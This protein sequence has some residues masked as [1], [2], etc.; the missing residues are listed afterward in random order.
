MCIV[1]FPA[2]RRADNMYSIP[3]ILTLLRVAAVPLLMILLAMPGPVVCPVAAVVFALAALTDL[4]DGMIARRYNQIT[5]VGKFLDP[6]ADKVLV[7]SALILLAGLQWVPA[8]LVVVIVAR[9]ILVTGLRA[10]AAE[11]GVVI[12]ADRYGKWKTALQTIALVPLIYHYPLWGVNMS[13]IGMVFL[14]GALALTVYS[15]WNYFVS[16]SGT[17]RH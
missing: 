2:C 6:V 1:S 8:W 5:T 15:G 13:A 11:Q 10:V 9:D 16:F 17:I 4:A 3:N 12:A 7:V 14:Y